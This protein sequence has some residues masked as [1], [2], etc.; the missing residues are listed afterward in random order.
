LWI[1]RLFGPRG[2]ATKWLKR[3]DSHAHLG[4][5]DDDALCFVERAGQLRYSAW[6]VWKGACGRVF[7]ATASARASFRIVKLGDTL[8]RLRFSPTHP[9]AI[10]NY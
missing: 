8:R 1:I 10:V 5:H 3:I 4:E 9:A 6:R 2:N 7:D